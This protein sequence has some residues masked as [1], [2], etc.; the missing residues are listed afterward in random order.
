MDLKGKI[1]SILKDP[2]T[3]DVVITL[4]LS[5]IV[6]ISALKELKEKELDIQLSK[7]KITRSK[8]ANAYF[9]AL[10]TQVA[11]A[12][13]IS[14]THAKNMLITRYGQPLVDES[15]GEIIT[16]KTI[17]PVEII[18]EEASIHALAIGYDGAFTIYQLF[19]GCHEYN[20]RE[21]SKLIEGTLS[22]LAEMETTPLTK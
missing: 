16:W 18:R 14:K 7:G 5:G 19:K 10:V 17:L 20:T 4:S 8:K 3:N 21:M 9:H 15:T 13:T 6:N 12:L 1:Q 22:E 2:E 11:E